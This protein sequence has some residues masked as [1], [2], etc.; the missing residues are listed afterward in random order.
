MANEKVIKLEL[1][2]GEAAVLFR[3]IRQSL[4]PSKGEQDILFGIVNEL[5]TNLRSYPTNDRGELR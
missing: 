2:M 3:V 1:T 5:E 4:P